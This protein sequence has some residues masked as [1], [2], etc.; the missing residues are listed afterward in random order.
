M[1]ND[2][3]QPVEHSTI[4]AIPKAHFKKTQYNHLINMNKRLYYSQENHTKVVN[5]PIDCMFYL[6]YTSN[7]EETLFTSEHVCFYSYPHNSEL[8]FITFDIKTGIKGLHMS[9]LLI[10]VLNFWKFTSY[11]SLKPLWSGMGKVVPARTSPTL[12]PP[13]P[14]TVHQLSWLAL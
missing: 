7:E 9:L 3:F 1:F 11:C 12:H 5:V 4:C 2:C 8:N 14:P 13:S 6:Y 10:K